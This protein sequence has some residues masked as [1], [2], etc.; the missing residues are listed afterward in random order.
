[1]TERT[2]VLSGFQTALKVTEA[3]TSS[4]LSSIYISLLG[5]L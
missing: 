5:I 2:A 3:D 1:M 4:Y